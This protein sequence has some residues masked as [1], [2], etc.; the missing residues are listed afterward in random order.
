MLRPYEVVPKL[1]CDRC[2]SQPEPLRSRSQPL[3]LCVIGRDTQSRKRWLVRDD[4]YAVAVREPARH[5]WSDPY[6]ISIRDRLLAE[7]ALSTG[8]KSIECANEVRPARIPEFARDLPLSLRQSR[9]L[10]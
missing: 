10:R 4:E 7:H 1:A 9:G 2:G 8:G 6:P 3:R 5:G